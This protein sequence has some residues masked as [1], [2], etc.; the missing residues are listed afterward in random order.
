MLLYF[1]NMLEG[2]GRERFCTFPSYLKYIQKY[3]FLI[4]Q[5]SLLKLLNPYYPLNA[6]NHLLKEK[7]M[8]ALQSYSF[9]S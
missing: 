7:E 5:N 8:S 4:L 9:L 6:P 2:G 1:V 3:Y